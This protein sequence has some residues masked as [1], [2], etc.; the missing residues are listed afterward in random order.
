[1]ENFITYKTLICRIDRF[2]VRHRFVAWE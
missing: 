2:E 1:M